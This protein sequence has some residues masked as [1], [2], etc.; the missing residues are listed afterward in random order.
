MTPCG[1]SSSWCSAGEECCA[2][3]GFCYDPSKPLL[4]AVPPVGTYFPCVHDD[5]CPLPDD[6]CMGATC[7]A[8]GGCKRP[9]TP[10]QCTGQWDPVCGCDGKT[11]T[12]EVCAWASRIA[13]DHKGQC[14]G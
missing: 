14:D 3:T 4:C 1:N 5:D 2:I 6:F 9:P 8:P 7:G 12:N 13:V 10:S 11:Y